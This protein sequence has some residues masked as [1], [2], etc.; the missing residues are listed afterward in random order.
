MY[1]LKR[2][3]MEVFEG[4]LLEER[5]HKE[6]KIYP[7]Y[8]QIRFQTNGKSLQGAGVVGGLRGVT[9]GSVRA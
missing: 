7:N 5:R 9:A 1:V 3:E 2:M 4:G 8:K 6:K